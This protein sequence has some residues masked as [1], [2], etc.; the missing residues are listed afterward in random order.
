MPEWLF[1]RGLE[2]HQS[3][4]LAEAE[5]LY[6]SVL[7]QL[8]QHANSLHLLGVIA[9][10]KG[11]MENAAALIRRAIAANPGAAAYHLNL[12]N[13]LQ[14]Q[15]LAKDAG[16]SYL[17]ALKFRPNLAEAHV[18]I[19][20]LF[21]DAGDPAQAELWYRSGLAINPNLAQAQ[22]HLGD[23]L[24]KQMKLEEA[25]ESYDRAVELDAQNAE[26][27]HWAGRVLRGLGDLDGALARFREAQA[28][29][30]D[31]PRAG[32]GE[33][34][35]QLLEGNYEDGWRNYERRWESL[36]HKTPMRKYAQPLWRG[37]RVEGGRVLLWPEQGIGDEI[38]FAGLLPNALRTGNQIV[39]ACDP[40]LQPLF[41][42]S[43]PGIEVVA[44]TRS[45]GTQEPLPPPGVHAHLPIGSL[46]G[47]FRR[48][49]FRT[50][51]PA[52]L[53]PDPI[54]RS[55][56]RER[57]ADGRFLIGVAWF[58]NNVES[59]ALRSIPLADFATLF[60]QPG[61]R[62]I[63]LQYGE[64]ERLAGEA[65][66]ADLPLLFD[67]MID[68]FTDMDG[69]AA[70][71]AALDLVITIDNTTAHVAGALG[72]PVWLLLPFAPDWRWLARGETSPW[73]P[74]VRLF[75]QAHRDDWSAVLCEV[76]QA[77]AETVLVS[78]SL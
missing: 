67:E 53:T 43:F 36:D 21:L 33:A 45:I 40:R 76:A 59:G 14:K 50:A 18:N 17:Q 35:V 66:A 61:C 4:R 3:G 38:M 24:R 9:F 65:N 39:L 71:V 16:V 64:S 63:S 56:A 11:E 20:G 26:A 12:G 23:A 42:R 37:Q 51:A 62:W 1:R 73:Y 58:S 54:Q 55:H 78:P 41:A 47:L 27:H 32:F 70:Q 44:E 19:G 31:H 48:D 34:M 68:Q 29:E 46:P 5:A 10:G 74:G 52:Y 57:Y 15:G 13:V 75:R 30:P 72:V 2:H 60:S 69:F 25:L 22:Y 8:P 28:I 7:T 6:R 49:G 77:L